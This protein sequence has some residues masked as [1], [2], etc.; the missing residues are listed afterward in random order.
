MTN[1]N[2]LKNRY[3]IQEFFYYT[4][5]STINYATVDTSTTAA[6]IQLLSNKE[7]INEI[8]VNTQYNHNSTPGELLGI[9]VSML[10]TP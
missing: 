6:S 8:S 7:I 9:L 3:N 4:D 5:G 10:V 2:T 1:N